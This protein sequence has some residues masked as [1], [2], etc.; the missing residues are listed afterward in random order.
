MPRIAV[1]RTEG[2]GWQP[3][4]RGTYD[5]TI[6]SVKEEVSQSG[7]AQLKVDG[8]VA[9]GPHAGKKAGIYYSLLQQAGWKLKLLLDAAGVEY[10]EV[11]TG[12]LNDKGKPVTEMQF[13][14]DD[15]VG[16]TFRCDVTEGVNPTSGKPKNDFMDE[17]SI[18]G[19]APAP[20]PAPAPRAPQPAARPAAARPQAAAQPPQPPQQPAAAGRRPQ[21]A[22]PARGVR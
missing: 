1:R 17:R 11:D 21:A 19:A 3:L 7:N 18:D 12:E 9:D 22:G 15:L 16:R 2:E 6:E 10:D 5:I 13:D 4:P 20:T 8:S 14:T